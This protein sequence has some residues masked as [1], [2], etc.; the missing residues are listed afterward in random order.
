MFEQ[1]TPNMT[2]Q[3]FLKVVPNSLDRSNVKHNVTIKSLLKYMHINI[4]SVY[5]KTLPS[6]THKHTNAHVFS[7]DVYCYVCDSVC[8]R[9]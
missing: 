8:M 3:S 4:F 7:H 5:I 9:V 1:Q 6:P 2:T